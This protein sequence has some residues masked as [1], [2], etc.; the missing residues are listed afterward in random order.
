M[1]GL[2]VFNSA[3]D[4]VFQQLNTALAEHFFA[5]NAD[6]FPENAT[7]SS[8]DGNIILQI[9]SPIINSQRIMH[10][11]FDNTYSSFQCENGL[12]F[13]FGDLL[14]YSFIKIGQRPVEILKRHL[15]VAIALVRH[16]YGANL[17][18]TQASSVQ[19]ELLSTCLQSYEEHL[20]DEEQA[21]LLEALPRLLINNEL[22]RV[23]HSALDGALERLRDLGHQRIH[24]L[25]FAS[26]KFVDSATSKQ[27][28]ALSATDLVFLTLL[29]RSL[30]RDGRQ[31]NRSVAVFLQGVSHDPHSGC[32]P[33]IAHF[34][35]L[36]KGVLLV[37]LVEYANLQ[38]A[39]SMYDTFF[40]LQKIITLQ[41]QGDADAMKPTYDSLES[42]VKQT[43]D[44]LKRSK[45]KGDEVDTS[46][47]KFIAKWDN[48]KKMYGD[49]FRSVERELLVR[50][51][52]N[53]PSFMDEL[54]QLFTLTCCDSSGIALDQLPEVAS[55][56]EGKMLE[57][58]E[59]LAVKAERNITIDAY[60]EDFPGLI[61]F[62]Y[63]NRS[64]GLMIAPDLRPNQ[65]ISKKSLWSMVEFTRNYLKKGHT[66]VMWKDKTFNYS[67][68][69]W[70]EDKS[71]GPMKSIDM[72]QH[73][74]ASLSSNNAFKPQFEPGLLAADYY[75]QLTE[76]CFP[77][78]S[79]GKVK[80]YE[81]F[82]IHL[83]L[84][85][86]TCAVE[87]SRR[88]AATIADVADENN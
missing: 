55:L 70:F 67:Y 40:V 63:V 71:G 82:C 73:V 80:C 36:S 35:Q 65:L 34:S 52:S 86:S 41:M 37:Q 69:L 51:E 59:F 72:Q 54:K 39:S 88:L 1:N 31:L 7:A 46:L 27:A 10:C 84:V 11:Q 24:A 79:P 81:L 61:H 8:I 9:F 42:F 5:K 16:L 85:T 56:V 58:S 4:V 23:V 44:A 60:L 33:C 77:K 32:V 15:G 66:T 47:K 45:L 48:L 49:F 28:L 22:K 87:H 17:F 2:I 12:N 64:T 13:A 74:V 38:V 50:I 83:G 26:N 78:A 3:N 30:Q 14:G 43:L 6:L 75:Q 29:S 18:A 20:W 25:L 21:L 68:F 53:I 76:I 19:E 62:V 57:I